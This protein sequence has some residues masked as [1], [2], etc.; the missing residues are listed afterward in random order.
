MLALLRRDKNV[1]R[2]AKAHSMTVK[3]ADLKTAIVTGTSTEAGVTEGG[4]NFKVSREFRD[5]WKQRKDRWVC[6]ESRVTKSELR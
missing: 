2:S 6:V 3:N 4:K 5:T 1:Y